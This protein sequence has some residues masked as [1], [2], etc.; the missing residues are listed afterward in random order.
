MFTNNFLGINFSTMSDHIACRCSNRIVDTI[1]VDYS[2]QLNKSTLWANVL[3]KLGIASLQVACHR[4]IKTLRGI[5]E[6]MDSE[7][8]FEALGDHE[9]PE[10]LRK[11][12]Y[13]ALQHVPSLGP[14]LTLDRHGIAD[15][16]LIKFRKVF[17]DR[18]HLIEQAGAFENLLNGNLNWNAVIAKAA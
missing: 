6:A 15:A 3:K 9:L 7:F 16:H 10:E 13:N 14:D 1:L 8:L 5:M 17:R 2:T 18:L 4:G 12:V 11:Q